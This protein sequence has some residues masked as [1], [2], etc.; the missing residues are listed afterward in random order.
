MTKIK[1]TATGI[2]LFEKATAE[3]AAA[4]E[5]GDYK[6]ANKSYSTI[7]DSVTY[8]KQE[9]KL[10]LLSD[11]LNNSHSDGVRMWAATYLLPVLENEA[12]LVLSQI[13]ESDEIHS[14]TAKATLSE[15]EKGNLKL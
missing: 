14:L 13:S 7:L 1:D 4:T 2:L 3:H 12:M 9:G 10:V 15:W 5:K 6:A 11:F 8:L